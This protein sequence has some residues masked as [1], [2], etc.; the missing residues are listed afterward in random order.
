MINSYI[1][2][3]KNYGYF[4]GKL[5]NKELIEL[6]KIKTKI[7]KILKKN[8]KYKKT[9]YKKSDDFLENF[10]KLID[11]SQLNKHRMNLYNNLNIHIKK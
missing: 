7:I 2:K 5:N 6:N 4:I 1:K 8:T 9:N 3:F 10:H 11:K